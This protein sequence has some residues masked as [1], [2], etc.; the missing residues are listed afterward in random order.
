[1]DIKKIIAKLPTGY[2]E[3]CA[4][5]SGDQLRAEI[6]KAET[7]LKWV[8]QEEKADE[9]LQGAKELVKD[10]GGAYRETKSAQAAKIACSLHVLEE[11]GELGV[12]A[13]SVEDEPVDARALANEAQGR[14]SRV[15]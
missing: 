4:G 9:K 1:M 15:A 7:S 13:H 14:A 5:M 12:G 2:A 3:D 11:R 10:L 6:I 8:R